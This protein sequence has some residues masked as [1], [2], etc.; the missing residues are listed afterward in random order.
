MDVLL[1]PLRESE[2][3]ER[4]SAFAGITKLVSAESSGSGAPAHCPIR[5]TLFKAHQAQMGPQPPPACPKPPRFLP[6]VLAFP[7]IPS[8]ASG[9][10]CRRGTGPGLCQLPS[11][12]VP[13]RCP[14]KAILVGQDAPPGLS[15]TDWAL[16]TDSHGAPSARPPPHEGNPSLRTEAGPPA[17][18]E[19]APAPHTSD[20]R[21]SPC[22]LGAPSLMVTAL[23][24]A[25]SPLPSRQG[26]RV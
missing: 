15:R 24:G 9:W 5:A 10:E 16:E 6:A 26:S 25:L 1:S 14:P 20:G 4:L 7:S 17:L 3:S 11:V 18:K 2:G 21:S 13:L 22:P 23:A 12:F 8:S 19:P